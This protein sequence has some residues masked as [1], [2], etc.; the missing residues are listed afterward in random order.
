MDLVSRSIK[1]APEVLAMTMT[2]K[3]TMMLFL[4]Q[5]L[6]LSFVSVSVEAR[7]ACAPLPRIQVRFLCDRNLIKSGFN[8]TETMEE[9]VSTQIDNESK[10]NPKP[11]LLRFYTSVSVSTVEDVSPRE[12]YYEQCS[13][14]SE[15]SLVTMD[16]RGY[17]MWDEE[18]SSD[19]QIPHHYHKSPFLIRQDL[20]AVWLRDYFKTKVC[21]AR[22]QNFDQTVEFW[23]D[24]RYPFPIRSDDD[25]VH[26]CPALMLPPPLV[27]GGGQIDYPSSSIHPVLIDNGE[28]ESPQ[29]NHTEEFYNDL[30]SQRKI[31]D[32]YRFDHD[33]YLLCGGAQGAFG[34]DDPSALFIAISV[35]AGYLMV[36]MVKA[37]FA[38]PR[39]YPE[40]PRRT[41]PRG[42]FYGI[43]N[44]YDND[45]YDFD[46]DGGSD[47]NRGLTA[48]QYQREIE[49]ATF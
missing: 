9:Y 12:W 49:L 16:A 3:M 35:L 22:I 33:H 4:G 1:I 34:Y 17:Y 30:L 18:S 45:D 13:A 27:K 29:E 37:E 19:V 26:G 23:D 47:E 48:R 42:V 32:G 20:M 11:Y 10:D 28:Y 7:M 38:R 31:T 25:I 40:M 44:G 14:K 2:M 24:Y 39:R 36:A 21:K 6:L 43:R 15:A 41:T 8:A 46:N 5:I